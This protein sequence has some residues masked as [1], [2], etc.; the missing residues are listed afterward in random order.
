[1]EDVDMKRFN[2]EKAGCAICSKATVVKGIFGIKKYKCSNHEKSHKKIKAKDCLAF[3]CN[4]ATNAK[5]CRHCRK[6]EKRG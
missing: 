4:S 5:E 3:R 1:M 6:G 2:C